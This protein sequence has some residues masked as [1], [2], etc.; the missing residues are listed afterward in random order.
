MTPAETASPTESERNGA[1]AAGQNCSGGLCYLQK[2]GIIAA[3]V[4]FSL[5]R[6]CWSR[7]GRESFLQAMAASAIFRIQFQ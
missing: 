6:H 5:G 4:I 2:W 1:A 3:H 7:C